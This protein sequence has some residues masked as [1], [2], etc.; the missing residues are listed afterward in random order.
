MKQDRLLDEII[1]VV[2]SYA[3]DSE[4]YIYG[5]RA[6]GDAGRLSDWDVLILVEDPTITIDFETKLMDQLYELEP[7]TGAI[8]SP[9]IYTKKEWLENH[10]ITPLFE[11]IQK[12]G[13]KIQ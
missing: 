2:N 8:F 13:V 9:L 3:P 10:P 4:I 12:E 7:E 5:S 6:R 11:N 1:E